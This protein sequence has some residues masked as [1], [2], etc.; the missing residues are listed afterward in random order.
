MANVVLSVDDFLWYVDQALR[1][2]TA[3]VEELGDEGANAP[4]SLPGA[5]SAYAILFHCLGVMEYWGGH[6][7]AG[8]TIRRDRD[9]EFRASGPVGPLLERVAAARRRLEADV[10]VLDPTAPPRDA[11]MYP[12]DAELPFGRSQGGVL[13][14][15]LEELYQHLGQMELT[16][17][18]LVGPVGE[19]AR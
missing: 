12:E 5:N 8:R 4:P 7:V 17:D 11:P 16:R 1:S 15:I 9:A 3:I 18:I 10:A 13:I 19:G 2:M 6:M 14:H